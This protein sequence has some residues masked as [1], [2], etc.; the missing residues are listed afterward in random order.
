MNAAVIREPLGEDTWLV[1]GYA[2]DVSVHFITKD[3]RVADTCKLHY[4][5]TSRDT[6]LAVWLELDGRI[7]AQTVQVLPA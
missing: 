2:G 1:T 6:H 7:L 3:L 4:A 5:T